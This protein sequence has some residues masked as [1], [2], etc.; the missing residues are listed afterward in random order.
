MQK[1]IIY[2]AGLYGSNAIRKI[3]DSNSFDILGI[4]DSK[5]NVSSYEYE[6]LNLKEEYSKYKEEIVLICMAN[7]KAV[8]EIYKQLKIW[9]F[10]KIYVYRNKTKCY[11]TD[12]LKD[13]CIECG[14]D[15][16]HELLHIEIHMA[17][18]CNLNCKGCTHFS[19]LFKNEFQTLAQCEK[20]I[21]N[22]KKYVNNI[23]IL[24]LLG[25]EPL[26]NKRLDE[27]IDMYRKELPN[28]EI[29]LVTN[30]LLIPNLEEKII[31]SIKENKVTVSISEYEPTHKIISKIK[32]KLEENEI[33]YCIREYDRKQKFGIAYTVNPETKRK[34]RC[35][36]PGCINVWNGK[37]SCCPSLM[38]VQRF[39]EKFGYSLPI[40]GIIDLELNDL[41]G[42][43]LV[44]KLYE[45]VPLCDYCVEGEIDWQRCEGIPT[46]E[47]FAWAD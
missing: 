39:N 12:F 43:D 41:L 1:V 35:L 13:E 26:L 31:K 22:L 42:Q 7:Y 15:F 18:H 37:I 45:S 8:A 10:T 46:R 17:D 9:G 44:S 16:S 14:E 47:D 38:Y 6:F 34:K 2:G 36:S 27:Y 25:G 33:D 4:Y 3:E 40:E 20:D 28:T 24:S 29:Q 32:Q 19:P 30:G 11:G 23:K 5:K 21:I